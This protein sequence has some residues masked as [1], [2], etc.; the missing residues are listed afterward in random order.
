MSAKKIL[1][2]EDDRSILRVIRDALEGEGFLVIIARDG[3]TGL[4]L[5]LREDVDLVILDVMLPGMDGFELCRRLRKSKAALPIIILTA[6]TKERDKLE[7]L[8]LGTDDYMTKPF[9]VKE[10]IARVKNRLARLHALR[11]RA[12]DTVIV[13]RIGRVRI[14]FVKM[15]AFKDGKTLTFS[16]REYDILRYML[17]RK[18]EVISRYDLLE[19]VWGLSSSPVTRTVDTFMS[20]IRKKIEDDPSEHRH[21]ISVRDAGYKLIV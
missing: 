1:V 12:S 15:E 16:K 2:V 14:D 4:D 13:Y 6:K 9:S 11:T 20:K 17:R 18:G 7:G 10:L 5:A 3:T 8:G 19:A 21:L